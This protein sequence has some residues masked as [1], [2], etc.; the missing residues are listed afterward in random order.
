LASQEGFYSRDLSEETG[1]SA[2][3]D[4]ICVNFV[5]GHSLDHNA[6][7]EVFKYKNRGVTITETNVFIILFTCFDP[8]RPSSG[9]L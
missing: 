5:F 9:D 2:N 1:K 7:S 8:D 3:M 6:D 4:I